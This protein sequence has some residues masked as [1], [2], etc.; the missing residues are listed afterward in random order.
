[1][2][3]KKI[4]LLILTLAVILAVPAAASGSAGFRITSASPSTGGVTLAISPGTG[5]YS[6]ID[7][8]VHL[9]HTLVDEGSVGYSGGSTALL[10]VPVGS[11]KN[12]EY[13]VT[14]WGSGGAGTGRMFVF[15]VLMG[16]ASGGLLAVPGSYTA[17]EHERFKLRAVKTPYATVYTDLSMSEPSVQLQKHD[18]VYW[19]ETSNPNIYWVNGY[20]LPDEIEL[21]MAPFRSPTGKAY[22]EVKNAVE[23]VGYM[24]SNAIMSENLYRPE[25]IA[26]EATGLAHSRIG[27][28]GIYSNINRFEYLYVD[29]SSFVY[30]CY[31]E[32][33][34]DFGVTTA[35]SITQYLY[36]HKNSN[37]DVVVYNLIDDMEIIVD[38][39]VYRNIDDKPV[40]AAVHYPTRDVALLMELL[41]PGDI[42]S[43]NYPNHLWYMGYPEDDEDSDDEVSEDDGGDED[44]EEE[45]EPVK[46]RIELE[47][48]Q[49]LEMILEND[50]YDMGDVTFGVDHVAIYIGDGKIIHTTGFITGVEE[51]DLEEVSTVKVHELS[52]YHLEAVIFAGRPSALVTG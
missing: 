4:I 19:R 44:D 40:E 28:H 47:N 29:C 9:D 8:M 39:E 36:S 3:V 12:G 32:F 14:A 33:G 24:Y 18:R 23:F 37:P 6:R 41:E 46:V 26:M 13:K 10:P 49:A 51:E 34:L 42:L 7:Y 50:G 11:M 43:F 16:G 2:Y 25:E 48:T 27:R 1:M 17:P 30:W 45:P 15:D 5:G 38:E 35:G 22:Y 20:L 52:L 31:K 21:E